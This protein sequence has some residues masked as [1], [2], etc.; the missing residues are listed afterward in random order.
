MFNRALNQRRRRPL[1][2]HPERVLGMAEFQTCIL[3]EEDGYVEGYDAMQLAHLARQHG[4]GRFALEDVIDPL[5]GLSLP[6]PWVK[7]SNETTR[8]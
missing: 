5:V 1:V 2:N 6:H 3:A 7:P 8:C 4:A